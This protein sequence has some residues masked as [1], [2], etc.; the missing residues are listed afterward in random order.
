MEARGKI[1]G[2]D[3]HSKIR[4]TR[5][6][7]SRK[8]SLA[9]DGICSVLYRSPSSL[10]TSAAQ[11]IGQSSFDSAY[12]EDSPAAQRWFAAIPSRF[13]LSSVARTGRTFCADVPCTLLHNAAGV[14]NGIV[15]TFTL[16]TVSSPDRSRS[17]ERCGAVQRSTNQAVRLRFLALYFRTCRFLDYRHRLL[18]TCLK[19]DAARSARQ[20][21][22]QR[23]APSGLQYSSSESRGYATQ[24][25]RWDLIP[26]PNSEKSGR[27][28][29]W[30][31]YDTS[32]AEKIYEHSAEEKAKRHP[33]ASVFTTVKAIN[34]RLWKRPL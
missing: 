12:H 14:F 3:P 10:G 7:P 4:R 6:Y 34:W 8:F 1:N 27:L 33:Y 18:V 11:M 29:L 30:R 9:A 2:Q 20:S 22:S 25:H 28:R 23:E 17:L 26:C 31:S 32:K 21:I 24:M 15:G 13:I 16:S 19:R 5:Q